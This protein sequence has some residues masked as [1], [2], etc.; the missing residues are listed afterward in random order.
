MQYGLWLPVYGGWLRADGF[1]T[2]PL[3]AEC[4][5]L[6]SLAER[7]GYAAV[8]ASENFLNCVHGPEHE[9][10][11]TWTLLSAVAARTER[12]RLIGA[13]KPA[14]RPSL[15]AA[16]MIATVDQ[17]ARGRV[18][19]NIACGWWQEEFDLCGANWRGHDDKYDHA[20]EY[21]SELKGF[22]SGAEEPRR[23]LYRNKPMS[24]WVGG[25]SDAALRFAARHCEVLFLN[26]MPP[27][28]VVAF[29]ERFRALNPGARVPR[30]VMNAFVILAD[31]D[32]AA[33]AR[34][35]ELLA[36]VRPELIALY[37]KAQKVAGTKTWSTLSDAE[38][39][40]ANGGFQAALMG[41]PDTVL[42]R[43]A[44]YKAAGVE[45]LLCQFPDMLTDSRSFAEK[46]ISRRSGASFQDRERGLQNV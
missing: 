36:A 43:A 38:L 6:A 19:I 30:I 40:D 17:L 25:H 9:V 22:W 21:V 24:F 23:P 34:K 27:E 42:A 35:A 13:L 20:A 16:Q 1:D 5:E 32:A 2:R 33:E 10:L 7:E 37:R 28:E 8:Y 45:M 29:R 18:E 46:I 31:S 11:D 4:L 3:A 12:I 39:I 15:V 26:G 44:D 41:A 14:F